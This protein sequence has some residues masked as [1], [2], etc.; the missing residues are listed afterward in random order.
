VL[1]CLHA[2]E[3]HGPALVSIIE[4]LPAGLRLSAADIDP[5]LSR[6][7]EGH[8]RGLRAQTIEK[9]QVRILSGLWK[10]RTLGSPLSMMI[11]NRDHE[12]RGGKDHPDWPAPRPGHADLAGRSKFGYD[13]FAPVAERASARATAGFVMTGAVARKLLKSFG[14]EIFSHTILVGQVAADTMNLNTRHRLKRIRCGTPLRC[15]DRKVEKIMVAEIDAALSEGVSLGGVSEVI[16]FGVPTGLGSYVH[17]D[18]RL[19]AALSGALMAIP[20]VKAVEIGEGIAGAGRSGQQAHDA[21]I[22]DQD[23]NLQ[24]ETNRAGGLEGGV[25]NG[26]PLFARIFVKPI[27]T[28]RRGVDSVN[29][30]TRK[31]ARAS[32][33]R[34]DTC[35][36]P[37][38]GV[39]AEAVLAWQLAA[40]LLRCLGDAPMTQL[41][42]RYK[43]QFADRKD[44]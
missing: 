5:E 19:D 33:V 38:A 28:Q 30:R 22:L 40:E 4:G 11:E 14:I 36:V 35:V 1:R 34:S 16:A 24:R 39:I 9:D 37:A 21:I 10:G 6:R 2:G 17:P 44:R 43:E 25:T 29:L 13:G 42:H 31:S 18:R 32:Y 20:S 3:S 23:G 7:L 26:M 8:G 12:L 27:S 41:I 15:L